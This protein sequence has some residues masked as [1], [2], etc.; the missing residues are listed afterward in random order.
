MAV[1]DL[2]RIAAATTAGV[3]FVD[4]ATASTIS[5][6]VLTG[7]AHGLADMS[8]VDDPK[9]YVTSGDCRRRRPTTSS[10]SAA[11]APPAVRSTSGRT[12]CRVSAR[13]SSTTTRARWSTSSGHAP[14]TAGTFEPPPAAGPA[15]VDGLRR[16]AAREPSSGTPSSPTPGWPTGFAPAAWAADV[17]RRLPGDDRQELLVFDAAGSMSSIELGS[18]AFAWRLPGVIAGAITAACLYLLLRILFRRRL[19]AVLAG[20]FVLADGMFFVQS[21]IGMNDVYVGLF[22]VAAYTVFA[23]L[24]TGW[25]R[26]SWAFWVGDA[27]HRRPARPRAREQVGGAL[28][29]RRRSPCCILAAQRAR[30]GRGDPRADRAHLRARLHGD[31]RARRT[32][33]RE[34]DVPARDGRR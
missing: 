29:D 1:Q 24:W 20:L 5:T 32:G 25:W 3:T 7:G 13:A 23:A 33:H 27:R 12:R 9:L 15:R 34:P 31:Q 21:R 18:H 19:V 30:A 8:G 11:T 17:E 14:T 6:V 2:P 10:R 4:P 26:A 28:R 16:R 22:I